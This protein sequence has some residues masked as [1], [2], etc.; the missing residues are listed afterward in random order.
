MSISPKHGFSKE[1]QLSIL[2]IEGEGVEGD[3]HRGRTVQHLYLK[4]KDPTTY[5]HSQVHL[6]AGEALDDLRALGFEIPNGGLGENVLTRGVDL[7]SLPE[8]TRLY[9]GNEAIVQLTGLRTPCS[10]IDGFRN[11]LQ[12][13][14]WGERG[15][16]GKRSRRAGVMSIVLTGG[17]VYP[18][19]EI[20]VEL[21]A[22]PH[23]PLR[24][25]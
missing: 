24:P 22:E 6:F 18:H 8:G 4:R 15:D 14:L 19:D 23:L 17:H 5:N 1:P 25:V 12:Q 13:H 10:Q 16:D 21:P 2:L 20:R 9:L 7:L 3:A 11:G